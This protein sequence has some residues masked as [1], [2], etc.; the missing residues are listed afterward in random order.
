MVLR[1]LSVIVRA[2]FLVAMARW[3]PVEDYGKLTMA[4][5]LTGYLI[6]LTGLDFYVTAHRSYLS[7]NGTLAHT[8]KAQLAVLG[9]GFALSVPT[10]VALQ[11]ADVSVHS[12]WFVAGLL[13]G[14]TACAELARLLVV[15]GKPSLA[16]AVNF[17]KAAGWMLPLLVATYRIPD[18]MLFRTIYSAWAAGLVVATILG[19]WGLGLRLGDVAAASSIRA[20]VLQ[21]IRLVPVLAVSTLAFRAL[22]SLDRLLVDWAS[23]P[24]GLAPYALFAGI[25]AAFMAL[26]DA[27]VAA[28]LYPPLVA[29]ASRREAMLSRH[30]IREI[31][32][33]ILML[34]AALVL[35][36]PLVLPPLLSFVGKPEFGTYSGLAWIVALG[37]A[38]HSVSLPFGYVLYGAHADRPVMRIHLHGALLMISAGAI[39]VALESVL[40]IAWAVCLS[41]VYMT[42]HK[43]VLAR[44]LI[45]QFVDA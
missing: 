28:R 8:A 26:V 24:A 2:S 20:L 34:S 16:N 17:V 5:A 41:F 43:I 13:V 35:S 1:G 22:F 9:G 40:W 30:L 19:L 44:R 6:Y 7:G 3:M 12:M 14:E 15:A 33:R 23:G 25:G 39:G 11:A 21:H 36:L 37:Y 31:L 32:L 27:G 18:S 10:L 29:A 38:V 42:T 45:R 4:F